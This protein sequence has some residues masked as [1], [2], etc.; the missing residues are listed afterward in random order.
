MKIYTAHNFAARKYL[1]D[2]IIP[3]LEALGHKVIARWATEPDHDK[4]GLNNECVKDI[5]DLS[6][7]D[8]ILLF[9][10]NFGDRPGRGKYVELGYALAQN[11]LIFLFGEADDCVF[12]HL[13]GVKRITNLNE[14]G[15]GIY[16]T[17]AGS[18]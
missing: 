5:Q 1:R 16:G 15:W 4:E 14:I 7:C 3:Q 10:D 11:K 13:P 8:A 18:D 6:Q 2:H 12:Y 9:T 17:N